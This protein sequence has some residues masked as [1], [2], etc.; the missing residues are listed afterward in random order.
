M[1]LET[2]VQSYIWRWEIELNFRDEKTVMGTGQAQVRT[3]AS[4][5][6]VPQLAVAA[7]AYLLLAGTAAKYDVLPRPKWQKS[8]P[9]ERTTTQ[10]MQN[11]FRAQLW[12]LAINGN[13]THFVNRPPQKQT[14]FYSHNTLNYAACYA[15]K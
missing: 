8:R 1:P 15:F 14:P 4:V 12:K 3:A 5:E 7:Y 9:G 2:L 10:M 6:S 11:V 13:K